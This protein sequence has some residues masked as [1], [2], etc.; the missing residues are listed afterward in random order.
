MICSGFEQIA[1]KN[2]GFTGKNHIFIM[3]L[4]VYESLML[5]FANFALDKRAMGGI[6]LF[7]KRIPLLLTKY[8]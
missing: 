8:K 6:A 7:G 3:F 2:E 4:T 5:L 1:Q